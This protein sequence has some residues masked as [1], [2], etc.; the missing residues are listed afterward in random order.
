ME[1][2]MKRGLMLTALLILLFCFSGITQA[3]LFTFYGEDNGGAGSATLNIDI[4]ITGSILIAVL[5]NT[6]PTALLNESVPNTPGITQ[7]GFNLPLSSL[8]FPSVSFITTDGINLYGNPWQLSSSF[9]EIGQEFLVGLPTGNGNGN[10]GSSV[11]GALYNPAATSGFAA[12][13]NYFTTATLTLTFAQGV[14][15]GL[16]IDSLTTFVRMQNV[17]LGGE[18]SLRLPGNSGT[19]VPE[20]ATMLLLG[21][22]LAGIAAFGRKKLLS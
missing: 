20:P 14:L 1:G 3:A 8:M 12:E 7:F 5:N 2:E 13:P 16:N 17:G 22:G 18:G 19:P 6:S 9:S 10:N 15:G 11:Q 4:D 21:A